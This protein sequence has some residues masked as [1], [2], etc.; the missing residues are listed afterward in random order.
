MGLALKLGEPS[1]AFVSFAVYRVWWWGN[2]RSAVLGAP[3]SILRGCDVAC[4]SG[5]LMPM[6]LLRFL[7]GSMP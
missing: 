6:L 3:V 2:L 7:D 5:A 4:A 1:I